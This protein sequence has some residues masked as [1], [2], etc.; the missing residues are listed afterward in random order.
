MKRDGHR[1]GEKALTSGE[2][3]GQWSAAAVGREVE[4]GG[5]ASSGSAK[6]MTLRFVL[7]GLPP[8]RPV[9]AAC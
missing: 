6:G 5:Q 3:D 8:F 2:Q 1:L 4:F 9:A 7:P